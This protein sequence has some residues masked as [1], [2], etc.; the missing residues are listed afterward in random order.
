V[1]SPAY[2]AVHASE[3]R[4]DQADDQQDHPDRPKDADPEHQSQD[5]ADQAENYRWKPPS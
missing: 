2:G 5:E 3:Q 4:K 1:T